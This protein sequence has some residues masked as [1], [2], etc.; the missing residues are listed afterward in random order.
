MQLFSLKSKFTFFLLVAALCLFSVG[1]WWSVRL[2]V[3]SE[4]EAR[5]KSNADRIEAGIGER[6]TAQGQ[7]LFQL[8]SHFSPN[9]APSKGDFKRIVDQAELLPRNPGL[10]YIGYAP[11][12]VSNSGGYSARISL[13]E[14]ADWRQRELIGRDILAEGGQRDTYFLAAQSGEV[15]LGSAS[16]LLANHEGKLADGFVFLL[17]VYVTGEKVSG[18]SRQP[19]GVIY[20]VFDAKDFFEDIFGAPS[21]KNES[22]NFS[23]QLG[24]S[25]PLYNRFDAGDL[26]TEGHATIRREISVWGRRLELTVY[27][28][29]RFYSF[30][31][32]YLAI[33][34]GLGAALVSCMLMIVMRASQNQLEFETLAKEASMEAAQ[35]S[36]RQ[37]ENL[38]RLNEFDHSLSGELDTRVLV[39]RFSAILSRLAE[40]DSSFIFFRESAKEKL[41]RLF[42]FR[43]LEKGDFR[44]DSLS[45]S[46]L[47]KMATQ[48]LVLRKGAPGSDEVLDSVIDA[49]AGY[50]DWF[51]FLISTREGGRCG[52][53]FT[54]K[55]NGLRFSE[56]EKELFESIVTQFASSTE[57]AQ[58]FVRVEEANRAKSA[59]LANMS[60]EIRTPLGAIIGFSEMMAREEISPEQR[61]EL[62]AHVRKN[63]E[64]LTCIIDDILDLAKVEAGKMKMERRRTSLPSVLHELHSVML[65]RSRDKK[66]HFSID[67]VGKVPAH[68]DTDE[69][70]LKQILMNIVG[71]AIKFT[72]RGSVRLVV[73]H[74]SG[75]KGQ[76]FLAF[77]VKDTGIGISDE[78]QASL[79]RP[80]SQADMSSTRR[81]G[82]SGLGLVLSRRL[83]QELGGDVELVESIQGQGSTFEAKVDVGPLEKTEWL[84]NLFPKLA[85]VATP[86]PRGVPRLDGAKILLVEDSE[87]NQDI[88]R[89]FLESSGANAKIVKDGNEAVEAAAQGDFDLILMDIQIPG[90]DGKEATRRIRQQGFKPPI[91]ALTAHAMQ[92][93]RQSCLN[94]GCVGQITKPISG[95]ALVGQVANYLRRA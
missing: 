68:I 72:D 30:G 19:V 52:L 13:A 45:D 50:S 69:V 62:S 17:P 8:R 59:F 21:L 27:P 61:G 55:K 82:G 44:T 26:D 22:V 36:R 73:R 3:W 89:Y 15:T 85:S 81:F 12:S 9:G 2:L 6:L 14:P 4:V 74:L 67:T 38:R 76:N 54:A 80:F 93:E 24:G 77:T 11:I 95:E 35:E 66:I 65:L 33:I 7:A 53:I 46:W 10:Q 60:H 39:E 41:L 63:G 23:L 79:F 64:Q 87:D 78:N 37:V 16:P 42:S 70:R 40:V 32:K 91:V 1:A 48:S 51:L 20:S 49:G 71:N 88:F 47:E 83:A 92:E 18:P 58:L 34:V 29:E 28:L 56:V 84:E 75:K 90:I 5:L 43:G 31:D 94:A 86:L 25:G 57:I